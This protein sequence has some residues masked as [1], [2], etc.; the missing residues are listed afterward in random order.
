MEGRGALPDRR[1][2]GKRR[3]LDLVA[4]IMKVLVTG[5]AGFI[6]SHIV[7]RLVQ[8]GY[9]VG[10]VDNLSTGKRRHVNRPPRFYRCDIRGGW[11]ERGFPPERPAVVAPPPAQMDGRRSRLGPRFDG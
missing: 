3:V 9:E 11:L 1:P 6:G 8:E 2:E 10:V 4:P 7:D 5:G